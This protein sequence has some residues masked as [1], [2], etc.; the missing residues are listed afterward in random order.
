M[1]KI[2]FK[3]FALQYM[4]FGWHAERVGDDE[5]VWIYADWLTCRIIPVMLTD[6]VVF[7]DWYVNML[8]PLQ[9]LLCKNKYD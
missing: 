2:D 9:N 6:G 3:R 7:P 1:I 8:G 5:Y 4:W